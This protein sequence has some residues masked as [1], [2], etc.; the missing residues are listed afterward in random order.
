MKYQEAIISQVNLSMNS[1]KR[2]IKLPSRVVRAL[3][4]GATQSGNSL[5]DYV[6]TV[7]EL[8]IHG[9]ELKNLQS[10]TGEYEELW[11]NLPSKLDLKLAKE[12]KR[13]DYPNSSAL[14]LALLVRHTL[15]AA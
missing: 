3:H 8:P 10:V 2:F 7:L 5:D 11:L 12:A 13:L 15:T 9:S 6:C 4:Y 14:I 1:T